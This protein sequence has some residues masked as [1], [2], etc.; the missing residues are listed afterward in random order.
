MFG[1]GGFDPS[2]LQ[3]MMEQMGIE[4]EE[5]DD[6]KEVV[7]RKSDR[8]LVIPN[9]Q[10]QITEAKGQKTYQVIGEAEERETESESKPE[11]SDDDIEMVVEQAGVDKDAAEKAL[12]ET[13][14]D[15][16]E[17]IVNLEK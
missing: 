8:E 17:A 7:I 9:P 5:L 15:I 10:V 11:I 16:A 3:K 1:R 12:K 13:D 14:G 4:V 2:Q 6:V